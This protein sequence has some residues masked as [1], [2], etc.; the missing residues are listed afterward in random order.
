MR[1]RR[2]P[3]PSRIQR[4]CFLSV[5]VSV[6]ASARDIAQQE[7]AKAENTVFKLLTLKGLFYTS[8]VVEVDDAKAAL[9]CY[10]GGRA[11]AL[12]LT[13]VFY[14]NTFLAAHFACLSSISMQSFRRGCTAGEQPP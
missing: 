12:L 1:P 8:Q 2:S 4:W 7:R 14:N 6:V 3:P 13:N 5:C 10:C 11:V 9:L